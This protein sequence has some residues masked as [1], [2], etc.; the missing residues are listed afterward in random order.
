MRLA[1]Q[2]HKG[3]KSTKQSRILFWANK[4]YKRPSEP[5]K[6]LRSAEG[7]SAGFILA[8][9]RLL[10]SRPNW[11]GLQEQLCSSNHAPAPPLQHQA[12][13]MYH[14]HT[15]KET[16]AQDEITQCKYLK[17]SRQHR[18]SAVCGMLRFPRTVLSLCRCCYYQQAEGSPCSPRTGLGGRGP[19]LTQPFALELVNLQLQFLWTTPTWFKN[20]L[21]IS[22]GSNFQ[23]NLQ[24][25][26]SGFLFPKSL[27]E[28]SCSNQVLLPNNFDFHLQISLGDTGNNNCGHKPSW[29][30]P[31][32]RYTIKHLRGWWE[33]KQSS[34]TGFCRGYK[35][36]VRMSH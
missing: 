20:T 29:S 25:L 27:S 24:I 19:N 31:Q 1:G 16:P 26:T 12:H 2:E 30:I 8:H 17:F 21:C 36:E 35:L 3:T 15:H 4:H 34:I 11:R 13:L 6:L 22:L 33:F 10:R 7:G 32:I 23:L 5:L 28:N 18:C 14:T 9:L